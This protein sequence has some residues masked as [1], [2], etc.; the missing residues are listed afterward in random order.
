MYDMAKVW[1]RGRFD[2]D[3]ERLGPDEAQA[4][5]SRFGLTGPFWALS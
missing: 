4:V 5:L 1:Y 2:L 3:W